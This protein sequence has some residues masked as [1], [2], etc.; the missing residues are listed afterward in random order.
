M[1]TELKILFVELKSQIENNC[2]KTAIRTIK[3]IEECLDAEF[4]KYIPV[5]LREK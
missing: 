2:Q 1:N 5:G 4:E 3:R